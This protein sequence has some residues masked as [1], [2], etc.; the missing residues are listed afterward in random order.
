MKSAVP[1]FTLQ[2]DPWDQLILAGP[3]GVRH[4][5][6][7]PMRSFPISDPQHAISV[8]DA[9]GHELLWIENLADVPSPTRELLVE[10]LYRR[11][12]VP[13]IERIVGLSAEVDP[14]QWEVETDRGRTRFLLNS[15]E[16]VRRLGAFRTL[17]LDS[18]GI[19]YLVRDVRQLDT[20]SRRILERYL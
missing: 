4:K 2:R 15:E 11:E 3:D 18:H 19:R 8:C 5:N 9:D 1:V 7:E 13:I 20:A 14:C 12:F 6:V 16:D 10:E 17:I